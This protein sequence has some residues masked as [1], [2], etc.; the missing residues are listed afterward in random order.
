M[1]N[2]ESSLNWMFSLSLVSA[3][4]LF[5]LYSVDVKFGDPKSEVFFGFFVHFSQLGRGK[6]T[7]RKT[8]QLKMVSQRWQES[9]WWCCRYCSFQVIQHTIGAAFHRGKSIHLT[10]SII[11]FALSL[12]STVTRQ[13]LSLGIVAEIGEKLFPSVWQLPT[14]HV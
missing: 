5:K 9:L 6:R 14:K 3:E 12:S 2:R 7:N 13:K 1:K 4:S 8:K 11:H 10:P